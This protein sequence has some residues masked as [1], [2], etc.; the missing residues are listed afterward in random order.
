MDLFK[1]FEDAFAWSYEEI[2]RIDP[3]IVQH[4]INTYENAKLIR[5]KL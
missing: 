1:E 2:P 3:S 5:Q 4:E